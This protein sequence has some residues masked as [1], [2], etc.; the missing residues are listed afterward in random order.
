MQPLWGS[1]VNKMKIAFRLIMGI[2]LAVL[3]VSLLFILP[4]TPVSAKKPL[5]VTIGEDVVFTQYNMRDSKFEDDPNNLL[6]WPNKKRAK[7]GR[8]MAE[9]WLSTGPGE[10]AVARALRGVRF[11]WDFG[12][13]DWEEV[14][15]LP[16]RVKIDFYYF[17]TAQ[18]VKDF[19]SSNAG[20]THSLFSEP[21]DPWYEWYDWIGYEPDEPGTRTDTVEEE[22]LTTVEGLTRDGMGGI[23]FE[24]YCQ[25]HSISWPHY[26]CA[27]VVLGPIEIEF[28]P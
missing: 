25:A 6:P 21:G 20:I 13:Y 12:P 9:V 2:T 5:T 3:L 26:S 22:Y 8:N 23:I 1:A 4:I 19:G 17:I 28:L 7:A 10:A 24:V 15:D 27:H 14:K 11:D 16:L 18:Y